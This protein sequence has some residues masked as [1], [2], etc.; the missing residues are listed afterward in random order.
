MSGS[1]AG[2]PTIG[3]AGGIG[4][5]KSRVAALLAELGCVV[6][7]SDADARAVLADPEVIATLRSW[8]GDD[9]VGVDGAIDRGKVAGRVFTDVEERR[10]LE[11]V[12]HPR[13]HERRA[14]RFA[15]APP[16]TRA[17]VIDAPLLFEAGLDAECDAVIFVDASRPTRLAR[18]AANRGWSDEELARR[19]SAQ[20]PIDRK[21]SLATL[22][23]D[24]TTNDED[25]L[26][27]ETRKALEQLT[28][29]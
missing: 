25:F 20:W 23:I 1:A 28:R 27:T 10:R 18:V 3:L 24:N 13:I 2:P 4:A 8:W 15:A 17:F 19:E 21:R 5:G 14:A 12:L 16:D 29:S 22:I 6:S 7:D 9:V 11:S 26:R